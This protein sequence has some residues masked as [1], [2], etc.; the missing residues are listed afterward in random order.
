VNSDLDWGQDLLR[1]STALRARRIEHVAIAYNGSADLNQMN[2][3]S[4]QVLAPCD[5]PTGWVAIS[6][7][8][9][10]LSNPSNCCGGY[11]WITAYNPVALVGKSIRLYW[12]PKTSETST[13]LN[14]V[15]PT[16]R[17]TR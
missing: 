11:K 6:M 15:K 17:V 13:A 7:F 4:F 9:I 2:L 14:P 5:R 1:L 10:K 3:P 16:S 12:I 8:Y